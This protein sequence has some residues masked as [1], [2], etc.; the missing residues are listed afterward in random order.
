MIGDLEAGSQQRLFVSIGD[1]D[2]AVLRFGRA[3]APPMLFAHANGFCASAYR[4]M[5]LALS[6]Q[7]DVF[8]V[9]LRGHGR[10]RLPARVAGHRS[11]KIF[12]D[13]LRQTK[14]ALRPLAVRHDWII[15]GHSLG[16]V[17]AAL[18]AA[19][20]PEIA[21]VRL[22]E[23]VAIPKSWTL[24]AKTPLW[25]LIAPQIP[26]VRAAKRRRSHWPDRAAVTDSYGRKSFFSTWAEG[27]LSD[28]LDDGLVTDESGARLACE[29]A[30]EAANF[31]AH[32]N[33]FWGCIGRIKA[34][35]SVLGARH[36]TSTVSNSA[37]SRL[38]RL[39]ARVERV[40]GVTHLV[41]FE[42]PRLAARFLAGATG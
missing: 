19:D 7:F 26:L 39:R 41:P 20:D 33:D 11:M 25:P 28:Y 8:A 21:A 6:D 14:A 24:I 35:V 13:D 9:D 30:W 4:R 5:F 12:G 18:A 37:E 16:G 2:V 40:S 15:A 3:G 36:P 31:A 10:T 34:P 17:A 1:G 29:P 22:I 23:P 27:V 42:D 32:A 38:K